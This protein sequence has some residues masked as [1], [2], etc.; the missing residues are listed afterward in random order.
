[1]RTFLWKGTSSIGYPNVAWR[2]ICLPIEEGG[3]GIRNIIALNY[4]L[5]SKHLWET[6][7]IW[8]GWIYQYHL[9]DKSVWTV[10][11]RTRSWKW[12]KLLRLHTV[13][14]P[15]IE[16]QTAS[17][18]DILL[19]QDLWH[20]IG[21]LIHRFPQSPHVV[22]TTLADKFNLVM[23]NGAWQW[24]IITDLECLEILHSLLTIHRGR[25]RIMW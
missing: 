8:V 19:W 5:M 20:E 24:P 18:E 13:L 2:Q 22:E 14:Q 1:M 12:R 10:N 16:Y 4:A 21:P 9:R 11:N 3:Q 17:W 7:P 6:S 25:D 23:F 15:H